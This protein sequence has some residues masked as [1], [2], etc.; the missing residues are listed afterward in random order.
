M[1]REAQKKGAIGYFIAQRVGSLILLLGGIIIGY[2]AV[3]G[4]LV[5]TGLMI[6]MGLLP[7]H[8]W[9]PAVVDNL[10]RSRLYL[11]LRWQKVAPLALFWFTPVRQL[12]WAVLNAVG[13]GLLM[14]VAVRVPLLLVFS[15][16][17]QMGWLLSFQ[18]RFAYYYLAL[19]FVVLG[20][21]VA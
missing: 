21:V 9:V 5:G 4:L 15:G 8:Y 2:L 13:G 3:G 6:K 10:T 20:L 14:L 12:P 17:V 1:G 16:M 11:L 19:Y 7:L 18:G